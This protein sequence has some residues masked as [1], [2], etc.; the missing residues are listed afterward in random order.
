[1]LEKTKFDVFYKSSFKKIT[2]YRPLLNITKNDII[3]FAKVCNL[4]FWYDD[5]NDNLQ[6]KRNSI[7]DF[8][9]RNIG[10]KAKFYN[11]INTTITNL[12]SEYLA[13]TNLVDKCY[14]KCIALKDGEYWINLSIYKKLSQS[15]R[16]RLLAKLLSEIL[17]KKQSNLYSLQNSTI[18]SKFLH[19]SLSNMPR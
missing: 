16:F 15:I 13:I 14:K 7:R 11:N 5:T 4:K 6:I 18:F 3:I 17:F 8:L 19:I 9:E 10:N 12:Q 1:M 2:V